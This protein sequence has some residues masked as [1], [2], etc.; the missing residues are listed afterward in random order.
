MPNMDLGIDQT[1]INYLCPRAASCAVRGML[2]LYLSIT[3]GLSTLDLQTSPIYGVQKIR[4]IWPWCFYSKKN[5]NPPHKPTQRRGGNSWFLMNFLIRNSWIVQSA[6]RKDWWKF[7]GCPWQNPPLH[8]D[9]AGEKM[10]LRFWGISSQLQF[11]WR[12]R[13]LLKDWFIRCVLD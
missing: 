10:G 3:G 8:A 1:L 4:Y 5:F 2:T 12:L 13:I 11:E 7:M 6:H 9:V